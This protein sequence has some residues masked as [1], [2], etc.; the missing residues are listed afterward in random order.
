M[1]RVN[2]KGERYIGEFTDGSFDCSNA[3]TRQPEGISYTLFDTKIKRDI[4]DKNRPSGP[5]TETFADREDWLEIIENDIQKEVSNGRVKIADSWDEIAEFIGAKPEVLKATVGQYNSF[6][7]DG[8]DADFLK[9]KRYLWPLRTP[10]YY[11]I[12]SNQGFDVSV[13]G[14][15]INHN[16]EV[17]NK[18]SD[19]IK[20]L[21][22]VGNDAG[23][24]HGSAYTGGAGAPGCDLSF[25]L[26]SG[27]IAGENAARYVLAGKK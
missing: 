5:N 26:C 9:D 21:Y 8:Y 10:P 22:A 3:L 20:G 25:A 13:G 11:A 14:I 6:C 24:V 16:M 19:A 7:D 15:K 23:C 2:K 18:R 4:I 27:C 17:L 12:L 1:V